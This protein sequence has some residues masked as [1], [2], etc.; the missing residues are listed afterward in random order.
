MVPGSADAA[1]VKIAVRGLLDAG[2]APDLVLQPIV[3]LQ[4][5]EVV[6]YEA[7]SRFRGPPNATPDRWFQ[8]ASEL[9]R[10]TELEVR[11]VEKALQLRKSLPANTFISLNIAPEALLDERMKRLLRSQSIAGTVFE[12]TEHC[13]VADYSLLSQAIQEVRSLGGFVAV[14]DAGAGYASL[15][16]ILELRPDFIKLDRSLIE[17]VHRNEAKSA[18]VEMFGTFASRVDAWILA[19]GLEEPEEL[20]RVMQLGVPLAQ[21]YLLGRPRPEPQPLDRELVHTMRVSAQLRESVTIEPLGEH[22]PPL[23]EQGADNELGK[24]VADENRPFTALVDGSRRPRWLVA[25]GADGMPTR[26]AAMC[27]LFTTPT[28]EALQRALTRPLEARFDP[29]VACDED[30]SYLGL[31]R[32]ER[33][34][35]QLVFP[36][37]PKRSW[38]PRRVGGTE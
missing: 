37:S 17:G 18:L 9:G 33:L 36:P 27:M 26:R 10:G 20:V 29:L 2:D 31:V 1:L 19:E 28:S 32:V 12:L 23:S 21:G 15:A 34:I 25:R 22:V 16:H 7:L 4:R 38:L 13:A 6:G 11:V 3:D 5:A 30:G 24:P 14:D 35:E 8:A